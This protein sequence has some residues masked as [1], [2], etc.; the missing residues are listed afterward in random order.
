MSLYELRQYQTF[1][2]NREWLHERF[3]Q[4]TVPIFERMG[5]EALG[6]FE[7]TAGAGEGDLHYLMRWE[8][9]E[10]RDEGWARFAA[11]VEWR[12]ARAATNQR[13]GPLVAR[14]HST[15]LRPTGYSRLL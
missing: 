5:F 4:H 13:H 3:A 6:F 1:P 9:P 11:D 7:V 14:T 2:H 12:E 10:A 8:S 15:L